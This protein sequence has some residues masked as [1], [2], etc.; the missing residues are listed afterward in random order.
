MRR[1]AHRFRTGFTPL[2]GGAGLVTVVA[3][4][5]GVCAATGL[6]APFKTAVVT[7]PQDASTGVIDITRV[8][9]G[10]T[11]KDRF[12]LS[13]RAA[14]AWKEADLLSPTGPPGSICAKLWTKAE[15]PDQTPDYLVCVTATK[16]DDLRG[17]VLRLRPNKLPLRVARGNV[18][19]S[20]RSFTL[21]FKQSAIGS[22]TLIRFAGESTRPGC[23]RFTCID[24]APNAPKTGRLK[25]PASS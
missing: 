6:A 21:T 7:D 1:L 18:D 9:L 10:T 5:I 2:R 11:T 24:L 22:P 25:L 19:K 8:S 17:S 15:P 16:D 3:G 14:Q 23:K 13:V 4:A 12:K 20:A